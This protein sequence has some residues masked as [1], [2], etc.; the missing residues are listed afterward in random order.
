[1]FFLSPNSGDSESGERVSPKGRSRTGI[2]PKLSRSGRF[3][4]RPTIRGFSWHCGR[5][6]NVI[7]DR[8]LRN[9]GRRYIKRW[10]FNRSGFARS[11]FVSTKT[12]I[13]IR[14]TSARL[15]SVQEGGTRRIFGKL[16]TNIVGMSKEHTNNIEERLVRNRQRS[17]DIMFP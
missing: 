1:M 17:H 14:T 8:R 12:I 10:T 6:G 9:R 15:A 13:R 16:K 7:G 2:Q 11:Q 5:S 3:R 4:C